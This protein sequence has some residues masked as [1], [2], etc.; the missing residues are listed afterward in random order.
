MSSVPVTITTEPDASATV[1]R[2]V[3]HGI[4][5]R[6]HLVVVTTLVVTLCSWSLAAL[7]PKRYRAFCIAALMPSADLNATELLR[8]VDSLERRNI[9][10]TVSVL[11]TT[12]LT[13]AQVL[14]SLPPEYA[15]GNY[16]IDS[17]VLPNTNLFRIEVEGDDPVR[18]A[19]MANRIPKLVG[20]Q[21]AQMYRVYGVTNVSA[22]LPP[23]EPYSPQPG[24]AIAAGL[25][26]GILI[27]V[28]LVW[29]SERY[30]LRPN[31]V[32]S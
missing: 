27:G 17:R 18:A 12:P 8:T 23:H 19:E 7:Q 28:V 21:A 1:P 14:A 20:A 4:R 15:Q 13:R 22:A 2:D 16:T 10:A 30:R 29:G 11:A 3:L 5:R 32:R 31:T 24:R 6:W 26:L 25:F 9:I